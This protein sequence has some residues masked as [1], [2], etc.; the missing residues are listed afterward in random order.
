MRTYLWVFVIGVAIFVAGIE[1]AQPQAK[2]NL[3][4]P[5]LREGY[6]FAGGKYSTVDGRHAPPRARRPPAVRA[7]RR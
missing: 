2:D 5:I 6:L 1:R 7:A 3:P 4:L